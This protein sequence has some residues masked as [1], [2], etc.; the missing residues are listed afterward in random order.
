M[1]ARNPRDR[2]PSAV[3]AT[4]A[5]SAIIKTTGTG[6]A[7]LLDRPRLADPVPTPD[8]VTRLDLLPP[9]A[10]QERDRKRSRGVAVALLAAVS[11]V[12]VGVAVVRSVLEQPITKSPTP[13][14]E[15]VYQ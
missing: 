7:E 15:P 14:T 11:A 2:Y 3:D 9:A 6:Y 1:L 8:A 5:L 13:C 10:G 4:N 12:C